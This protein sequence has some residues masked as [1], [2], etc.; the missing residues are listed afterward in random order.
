[1]TPRS[2]WNKKNNQINHI[3]LNGIV[4]QAFQDHFHSVFRMIAIISL[5]DIMQKKRKFE[6]PDILTIMLRYC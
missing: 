3:T 5:A 1:M 2:G 6:Y 4:F